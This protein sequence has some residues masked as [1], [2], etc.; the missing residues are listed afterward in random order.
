MKKLP[1]YHTSVFVAL[2][3]MLLATLILLCS[4]CSST[5]KQPYG[6]WRD[7]NQ[8]DWSPKSEGGL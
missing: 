7:F 4:S 5:P 1:L 8:V 6:D 2:A 3:A